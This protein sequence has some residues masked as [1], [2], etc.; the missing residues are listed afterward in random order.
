MAP[1]RGPNGALE[2]V[3]REAPRGAEEK[4]SNPPMRA[5]C[6][7]RPTSSPPGRRASLRARGTW[8]A[9]LLLWPLVGCLVLPS[10][11]ASPG[12]PVVGG[13][14]PLQVV[15]DPSGSVLALVSITIQDQ[16]PYTFVVDTG[17][18]RTV[19]D[20]PVADSLHLEPVPAVPIAT[21]VSGAVE[22]TVVRVAQWRLGDVD[23]P[24]TIV[25][26]IDLSGPNAPALQQALGRRI[27][28]LLGSDLLSGYGAI[29][30]DYA[31]S[32]LILG[33]QAAD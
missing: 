12:P 4:V 1:T 7:D 14:V 33:P 24:G 28:G 22:A 2:R 26:S 23:L 29:T 17:A 5:T 20:R 15:K 9:V 21:D 31:R 6:S 32:T 18:S 25:A 8:L 13:G 10:Q 30:L 16:G 11:L 3:G 19:I 27:D